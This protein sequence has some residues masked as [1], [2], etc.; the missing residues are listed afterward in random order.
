VR[1]DISSVESLFASGGPCAE[2]GVRAGESEGEIILNTF[3][4][5]CFV[6]VTI[7]EDVQDMVIQHPETRLPSSLAC[8]FSVTAVYL[9]ALRVCQPFEYS[10]NTRVK[11]LR[12][13]TRRP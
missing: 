10:A 7:T 13:N 1:E 5:L 3:S 11:E 12:G 2:I 9:H 8:L 4:T 6:Y